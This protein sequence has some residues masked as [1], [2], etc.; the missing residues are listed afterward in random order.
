MWVKAEDG[1]LYNL[2]NAQAVEP[3]ETD[4]G[5]IVTV[6]YAGTTVRATDDN[7]ALQDADVAM[8]TEPKSNTAALRVVNEIAH[9]MRHSHEFDASGEMLD[10]NEIEVRHRGRAA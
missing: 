1:K 10:L 4:D 2:Q 5:W 3:V 9:A 8:L 7:P 6:R